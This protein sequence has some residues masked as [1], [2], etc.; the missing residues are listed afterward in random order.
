MHWK[1]GKD[2]RTRRLAKRKWSYITPKEWSALEIGPQTI[3][4]QMGKMLGLHPGY[5]APDKQRVYEQSTPNSRAIRE[6]KRQRTLASRAWAV[7]RSR[8]RRRKRPGWSLPR[9]AVS[10]KAQWVDLL[11]RMEPGRW[12]GW[13]AIDELMGRRH[14]MMGCHAKYRYLDK[15]LNPASPGHPFC[16]GHAG[17][18]A[19]RG[20]RFEPV[21][22]YR[23]NAKGE[24]LR[25]A[26]LAAGDELLIYP[27]TLVVENRGVAPP[28]A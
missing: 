12:Y 18:L 17:P 9:G 13:H 4:S 24:A 3:Q 14:S 21:Y 20:R 26:A 1:G 19:L 5:N 23:L 8:A 16:E 15:G 2:K 27:E 11:S 10:A 28:P 7:G 6:S 22:L 25:A